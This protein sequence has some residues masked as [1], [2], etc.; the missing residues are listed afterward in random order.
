MKLSAVL[1]LLLCLGLSA[2]GGGGGGDGGGDDRNASDSSG[3]TNRFAHRNEFVPAANAMADDFIA[4][5]YDSMG[6]TA[7]NDLTGTWVYLLAEAGA[8]QIMAEEAENQSEPLYT[9]SYKD[10]QVMVLSVQ[11]MGDT[12]IMYECGMAAQDGAGAFIFTYT[13]SDDVDEITMWENSK[14][15]A[16]T[17]TVENNRVLRF[18]DAYGGSFLHRDLN[19]VLHRFTSSTSLAYVKVSPQLNAVMGVL[20]DAAHADEPVLCADMGLFEWFEG[21]NPNKGRKLGYNAQAD[22]TYFVPGLSVEDMPKGQFEWLGRNGLNYQ[23]QSRAGAGNLQ[24]LVE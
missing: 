19:N 3:N 20:N 4:S 1:P 24:L 11:D 5:A 18:S 23:L 7:D 13:R 15:F 17:G 14:N 2:C 10:R 6:D 9:E 21:M 8:D 16:R 22:L 12:L